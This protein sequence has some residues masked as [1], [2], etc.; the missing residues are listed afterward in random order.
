MKKLLPFIIILLII[1]SCGSGTVDNNS[2]KQ[3]ETNETVSTELDYYKNVPNDLNY[4]GYNFIIFTYDVAN[5]DTYVDKDE[6]NGEILND[7]AYMRNAE[8]VDMLNI[9]ISSL[10]RPDS[11]MINDVLKNNAAGDAP[12]DLILFWSGTNVTSLITENQIYDWN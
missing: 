2:G 3:Q 9:E 8:V 6:I 7:A 5:W 10:K 4:D 1:V 12:Y 11:G